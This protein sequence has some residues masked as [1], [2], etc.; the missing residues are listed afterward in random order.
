MLGPS[1]PRPPSRTTTLSLPHHNAIPNAH[2]CHPTRVSGPHD[3]RDPHAPHAPSSP[4]ARY[5][6]DGKAGG[7]CDASCP[8][9][10]DSDGAGGSG[11]GG[12]DAP[13]C[14]YAR[15]AGAPCI[16]IA[17]YGYMLAAAKLFGIFGIVLYNRRLARWRYRRIFVLGHFT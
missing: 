13:P 10:A 15:D 1:V 8:A 2:T 14:G 7:N 17:Y 4:R 9:I 16:D 3:A 12:G 5:H 11:D 6:D